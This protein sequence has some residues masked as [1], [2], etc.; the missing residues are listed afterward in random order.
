MFDISELSIALQKEDEV[1][2]VIRTHLHIENLIN[3]FLHLATPCPDYLSPLKL[4]Y[5][6]KVQLSLSLGLPEKFKQP[7]NFLG[8]I[9]NNFAHKLNLKIDKNIVNNFFDTFDEKQ[10][11]DIIE[12]SSVN[13]LS[14]VAEGK[15]W[16]A[17]SPSDRFMIMSF[18]LYYGL[19]MS[20]VEF[21]TDIDIRAYHEQI[22]KLAKTE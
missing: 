20:I 8:T 19:K 5:F 11:K 12:S 1:G 21:K 16:K 17:I 2:R 10:K 18:A 13:T 3:Q 22:G 6:G 7:L 4:D 14:W 9:R 15:S